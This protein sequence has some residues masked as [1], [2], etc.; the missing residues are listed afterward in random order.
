MTPLSAREQM[1]ALLTGRAFE[2]AATYNVSDYA[3]LFTL[4]VE[5]IHEYVALNGLPDG[6]VMTAPDSR[7]G[8]YLVE[9]DGKFRV[10][11]QDRGIVM[12]EHVFSVRKAAAKA[13]VDELLINGSR[14]L[15]RR[16]KSGQV[17]RRSA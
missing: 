4:S 11:W 17:Q 7:D 12:V 14:G 16:G 6:A 1:C 5:E 3:T 9:G 10:Y 15:Y 2:V 8:L 13:A